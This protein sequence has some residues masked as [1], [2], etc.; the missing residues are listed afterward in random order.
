MFGLPTEAL[1]T[2]ATTAFSFFMERDSRKFTRDE[3]EFELR[4]KEL[5]LELTIAKAADS[6]FSP[7]LR[8][9]LSLVVVASV[10]YGVYYAAKNVDIPLT[11]I[12]EKAQK[13]LLGIFKWGK[14]YEVLELDGVALIPA[15]TH[16]F[17]IIIGT[18]IGR[19]LARR[20]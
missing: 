8:S 2:L 17:S 4:K 12:Q 1:L 11:I 6:R 10:M 7:W 9:A 15:I 13:S 14:T 5:E 20:N 18:V 3:Q 19:V 16:A